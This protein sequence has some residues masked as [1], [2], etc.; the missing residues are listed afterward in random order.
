LP[1]TESRQ[2]K[3]KEN[4]FFYTHDNICATV[5]VQKFGTLRV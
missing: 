5:V 4:N 2:K 1:I 3:L